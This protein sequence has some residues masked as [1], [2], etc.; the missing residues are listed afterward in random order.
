[1]EKPKSRDETKRATRRALLEAGLAEIVERGLDAPSLDSICARAGFTRGAFYVHF[2]NRDDFL[3]QLME[4][5]FGNFIDTIIAADSSEASLQVVIERFLDALARGDLPLRQLGLRFNQ[6]LEATQRLPQVRERFNTLNREA[7][8]R[9]SKR[10]LDGQQR[11]TTRA[12]VDAEA[13]ATFL[14]AAAIGGMALRDAGISLDLA[15][16]AQSILQV[17]EG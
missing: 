17:V 15:R 14:V 5:V 3:V 9:V 4:W 2:A 6:M 11:G 1:M 7:I 16:I 8:E 10:V 13:F 12:D